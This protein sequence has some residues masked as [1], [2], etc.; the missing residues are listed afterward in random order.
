MAASAP[1]WNAGTG[2]QGALSLVL[3]SLAIA[4]CLAAA[5]TFG[6]ALNSD[7]VPE[8]A[9][10]QATLLD[11][12]T[13]PYILAGLVAWRHRPDSRFGPRIHQKPVPRKSKFPVFRPPAANERF[14]R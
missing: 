3:A 11:W 13:L 4:G 12:I 5:A 6:L 14:G 2:A 7:L 9:G 10:L 1:P 8:P